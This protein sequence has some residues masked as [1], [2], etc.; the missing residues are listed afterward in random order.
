[1]AK[2]DKG[3]E[4]K[5]GGGMM[6]KIIF[7]LP[8]VLLLVGG[9]YFFLLAPKASAKTGPTTTIPPISV[10]FP[11]ITTNLGDGHVL[12]VQ[13]TFAVSPTVATPTYSAQIT[14]ET[15]QITSAIILATSSWTY[16]SL[17][18]QTARQQLLS[19]VVTE[20]NTV[21]KA[22]AKT[23]IVLGAYYKNFVMQ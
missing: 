19:Q 23:P 12:Q 16:N 5:S 22:P 6:K 11:Q 14:T 21:L 4:E 15:P 18:P 7:I 10:D 3:D 2:K 1:M 20:V 9:A 8:L 17:L 13:F